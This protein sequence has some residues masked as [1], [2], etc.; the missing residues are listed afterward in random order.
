MLCFLN[1]TA[2]AATAATAEAERGSFDLIKAPQKKKT[3]AKDVRPAAA[4]SS[5]ARI[6]TSDAL[7][8]KQKRPSPHSGA[9]SDADVG[10]ILLPSYASAVVPSGGESAAGS[11]TTVVSAAPVSA[12]MFVPEGSEASATTATAAAG[13]LPVSDIQSAVLRQ[14]A[15]VNGHVSSDVR[16][17]PTA[18]TRKKKRP[19]PIF[20]TTGSQSDDS[21]QAPVLVPC[22]KST[23]RH[24]DSEDDDFE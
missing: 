8:V 7:K 15:E 1:P 19:P 11:V 5:Y 9:A 24:E 10:R 6:K 22:E 4:P 16:L 2:A 20:M 3:I 17:L 21:P 13:R 12:A 18:I 14:L 23:F